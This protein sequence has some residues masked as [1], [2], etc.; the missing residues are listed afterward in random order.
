[1]QLR[2]LFEEFPVDKGAVVPLALQQLL[3]ESLDVCDDW[4]RAEQLLLS[5]RELLPERLEI[6]VALYKMYAYSNRF[7]EAL[8]LINEVLC[9]AANQGGFSINWRWLSSSSADWNNA[10]GAVRF[11]LYSLKAMGFVQLRKGEI[12]QAHEVLQRLCQLDHLDQVGGSVVLDM[13]ERLIELEL[14]GVS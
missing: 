2:D 9:K 11:Y 10:K 5:A 8:A 1:M 12:S 6:L 13:A 4:Q 3:R 7:D 14:E